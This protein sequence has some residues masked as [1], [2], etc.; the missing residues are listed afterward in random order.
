MKKTLSA[1]LCLAV[2]GCMHSA[3]FAAELLDVKPVVAGNTVSI[4]ISAD[5][6]MTYT[7]Y[8]VPGQ[9]RAVVDIAEADPEKVEPLIVV[10]KGAVSSISVD[11]AQ[12]SGIVV[13]R[14]IF[15]LVS[16]TDITVSA[17]P[18]RKLLT[19]TFGG[20]AAAAAKTEPKPLPVPEPV[21][22]VEPP[23]PAPV[24]P[25]AATDKA[26]DPLGLDEPDA[27]AAAPVAKTTASVASEIPLAAAPIVTRVPKLEPVVPVM[28]A[29]SKPSALSI[30]E[31]ASGATYIEIR[32]NQAIA[33]YKSAIIAGPERLVID[34]A[35]A[36]IQQKAKSVSINKFGITKARI[37]VSPKN[38]RIV[39][40]SGKTAFPK[41]T[42]T[43]TED[44]LRI[45][46]K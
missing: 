15:N 1:I 8:K 26:D 32:A 25:P 13:S 10:N 7:Y 3:V 4:E 17:S 14:L 19:V 12:I 43:S 11:K 27:K 16:E 23:V 29:P 34:I 28:A 33:D 37:G 42:I 41:H 44:G 22:K 35:G 31:I 30:K 9:A 39:I 24:A 36:K 46:F 5:I 6:A 20:S 2:L 21:A 18:D 38:I 45:N 40:D